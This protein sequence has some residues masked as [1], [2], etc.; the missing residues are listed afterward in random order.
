MAKVA[1]NGIQKARNTAKLY[2]LVW[3][4]AQ[5]QLKVMGPLKFGLDLNLRNVTCHFFTRVADPHSLSH[6]VP[7]T[8]IAKQSDQYG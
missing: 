6:L 4:R 3:V 5:S 8:D 2:M 1:P 7:C